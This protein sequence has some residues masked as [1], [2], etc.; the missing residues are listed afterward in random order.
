M[1]SNDP[2]EVGLKPT[3]EDELEGG[4]RR[5]SSQ[6]DI[7]DL[8]ADEN[9]GRTDGRGQAVRDVRAVPDRRRAVPSS[10]C[11][12]VYQDYS[13][14]QAEIDRLTRTLSISLGIGLLVLYAV[15]LPLMIGVTRTLRTSEP[16][17]P[18]PGGPAL[19]PA[20]ARAGHGR[21]APR[22]GPD[23]ERLR[24]RHVARA[25]NTAHQHP[26]L[27]PHPSRVGVGRRSGGG[28]G[29]RRRSSGNPAGCS[30]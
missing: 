15:L 1:F 16:S 17:A 14:I 11:I 13:V 3:I 10:A 25:A 7:S 12:E 29:A 24:R 28:R 9:V 23:E 26:R 22:A 18:G 6:S 2:Q 27:R 20:G 4:P 8:T 5:A 30:V 19:R 21:G